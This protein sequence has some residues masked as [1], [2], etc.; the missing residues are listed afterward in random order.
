MKNMRA[1]TFR[2][3]AAVI[4]GVVVTISGCGGDGGKAPPGKDPSLVI[5][6]NF[7]DVEN[8]SAFDVA[9]ADIG[10]HKKFVLPKNAEVRQDGEPGKLKI[11]MKKTLSF[12]G[13][14]PAKMSIRLGRKNMGC[15]V[16]S[17]KDA[18]VVAT[19]GEFSTRE[20][21]AGMALLIIVP[22]GIE[23]ERRNDL[24]GEN[25]KGHQDSKTPANEGYWYGPSAPGNGWEAL[26][27]FPD[28][29]HR[30]ENLK[31]ANPHK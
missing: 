12:M 28:N 20:G 25:S 8:G 22:K 24:S 29:E 1:H 21:G 4:L 17:E 27:A 2:R 11:Y 16:Q 3:S 9:V 26:S 31:D 23:I 10:A 30:A 13:H 19:Y 6:E 15:A 14:P 18:R 7:E 5:G